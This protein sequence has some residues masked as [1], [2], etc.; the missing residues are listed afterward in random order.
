[1]QLEICFKLNKLINLA[2]RLVIKIMSNKVVNKLAIVLASVR[3]LFLCQKNV[4][5]FIVKFRYFKKIQEK[6]TRKK[7]KNIFKTGNSSTKACRRQ[8]SVT[9]CYN[10]IGL[11]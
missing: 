10:T 5:F 11:F 9:Y 4:W 6:E 1:M 3:N 8:C 7:S 2:L